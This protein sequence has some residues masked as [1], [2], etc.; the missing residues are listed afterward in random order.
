[1]PPRRAGRPGPR[2]MWDFPADPGVARLARDL[3]ERGAVLAAVCHGPSALV[4]ATLS[5]GTP[6]VAGRRVAA[7]TDSEEHAAGAADAVPF[8]LQTRLEQLGAIHTGAPDWQPHV[9]VDGNLITGQNPA[10]AT[11]VAEAVVATA[12]RRAGAAPSAPSGGRR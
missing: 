1:M 3:Y 12:S 4:G 5:D 2:T 8:L 6:L 10:S 9:V 7:F 11:G